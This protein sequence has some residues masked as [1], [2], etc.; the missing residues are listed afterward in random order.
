[1]GACQGTGTHGTSA[2][3]VDRV[4]GFASARG[5]GASISRRAGTSRHR[6]EP[7]CQR[8]V[9]RWQA[10]QRRARHC[11]HAEAK[12]RHA[13]AEKVRRQR[14]KST[15][16]TLE[17]PE[18]TPAAWSRSRKFF[19]TPL[20]DRPG[21]HEHPVSSPRNPARY[22]GPSCRQAVRNVQDGEPSGSARHLGW[23]EETGHRI[24]SRAPA[25]WFDP[26]PGTGAATAEVTVVP[27]RRRSSII[28]WPSS[29]LVCWGR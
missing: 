1:M 17:S 22:C 11:Q 8:E 12:A 27:E 28:A 4:H 13:Q 16:Q 29:A 20:C 24:P 5:V 9:H 26:Q 15:S 2:S 23:A 19:P 7:E 18:V 6:Q 3:E 25:P 14:A 10:V 21:C